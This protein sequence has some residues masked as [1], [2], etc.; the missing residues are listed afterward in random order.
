[1]SNQDH[2][3]DELGRELHRRVD[4]MY[5]APLT[6]DAVRGRARSIRRRRRVAAASS[7]AAAVAVVAT[8]SAV[9]P[10]LDRADTPQPAPEP[11]PA[12]GA[13]VLHDGVVTLPGGDTVSVDL[14]NTN[15]SQ[16]GV[17]T[18]GRIVVANQAEQSVQVFAPDGSLAATYPVDL[19]LV[20]MSSTDELAAWIEGSRVQVL[21]SGSTDPVALAPLTARYVV[22]DLLASGPV[23]RMRRKRDG[24]S[25]VRWARGRVPHGV[26]G[27]HRSRTSQGFLERASVP[28][29]SVE[30]PL[31]SDHLRSA[32]SP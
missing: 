6:L 1:M 4:A 27:H 25:P 11:S 19:L 20:T 23:A 9:L 32:E 3:T 21:E 10:G 31:L 15:V 26:H 16:F 8:L 29:R 2:L 18:D 17:L 13:S 14:A 12:R 28:H 30:S 24:W 22:V 7:I 5:D